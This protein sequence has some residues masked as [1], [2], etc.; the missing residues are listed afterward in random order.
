MKFITELVYWFKV[1]RYYHKVKKNHLE[2]VTGIENLPDEGPF[3]VVANHSSFVD[4]YLVGALFKHLYNNPIYFLT[5]KESFENWWSRFWHRASNCIPVDR[6][7]P[8]IAAFKSMMAVLKDKKILVIYPEGTRGPGDQLLPFKTGAFKIAARMKVPIIPIG[9]VGVHKV[10][11]RDQAHFSPVRASVNIGKPIAVDFIKQHSLE[12]LTAYTK[13]RIHE[14]CLAHDL[15]HMHMSNRAAS[16]EALARR[17]ESRIEAVLEAG[18]YQAIKEDFGLYEHAI[19]YSF[20]NTP[21]HIPTMVQQARLMGIRALTSPVAFFRYIPKVKRLAEAV[22]ALDAEHAFAH[23]IL[24][25]YYLKMPR[26]LGGSPQR[27]LEALSVAFQNAPVYGIEQNKFTLTLAEAYEKTGNKPG[28]LQLLQTARD[29]QGEGVRFEK[30]KQR[31]LHKIEQLTA[32]HQAS[33]DKA[34]A[35]AA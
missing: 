2:S 35:S 18:D 25:Q 1:V 13:D 14:L 26:L 4:H 11:P 19:D 10:M 34:A 8:D 7:K 22:I 32:Q 30:R 28:A 6:E 12:A 9:L 3:I 17:V 27:A 5:K 31:I 20:L 23:Y 21:R 16:S 24:G 33:V 29:A 15:P